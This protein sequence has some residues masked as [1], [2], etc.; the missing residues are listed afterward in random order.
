MG[1][2]RDKI[3]TLVLV[4]LTTTLFAMDAQANNVSSTFQHECETRGAFVGKLFSL[5]TGGEHLRTG[6]ACPTRPQRKKP[7]HR[8]SHRPDERWRPLSR[9]TLGRGRD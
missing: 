9:L 6:C 5:T 3:T 8:T 1:E 4:G 7:A 2:R